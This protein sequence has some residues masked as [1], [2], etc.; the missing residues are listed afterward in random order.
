MPATILNNLPATVAAETT[1]ADPALGGCFFGFDTGPGTGL[2]VNLANA[3]IFTIIYAPDHVTVNNVFGISCN[4]RDINGVCTDGAL[5]FVTRQTGGPGL[6]ISSLPG[7]FNNDHIGYEIAGGA[8][9][10]FV[11]AFYL[12]PGGIAR[13]HHRGLRCPQR[14]RAGAADPVAVRRRLCRDGCPA[15]PQEGWL[16]LLPR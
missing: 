12:N 6:D 7:D 5:A 3:D 8:A 16:K 11:A 13:Q 15:P 4:T 2:T 1:C 10:S 14:C 9:T